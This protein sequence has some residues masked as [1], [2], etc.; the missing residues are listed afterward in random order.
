MLMLK[1]YLKVKINKNNT[2]YNN[3]QTHIMQNVMEFSMY[4]KLS[5]K[6][7]FKETPLLVILY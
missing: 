1:I 3:T 7:K 6:T 2:N 5:Y 4:N